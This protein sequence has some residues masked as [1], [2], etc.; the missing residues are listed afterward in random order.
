MKIFVLLTAVLLG[1]CSSADIHIA[2]CQ[3]RDGLQPVCGIQTPEDIAALDDGRHLLLAH[4]GGMIGGLGSLSLFDTQTESVTPLFPS[5]FAVVDVASATW[6]DTDC[7]APNPEKFNPHGTHLHRLADGALRY[8]V[9]NHGER[10]TV[11]M[12]EVLGNGSATGLQWRGCLEPAADTFM[13]D[14]VGLSNGDVIYT[15]MFHNAGTAEMLLSLIG[16]NTGDLWR[17]SKQAGPQLLPGTT[18][19]QPNGLEISPDE[20]HVFANMY[21]TQELWKVDVDTGEIVDVAAVA[22]ADNSAWGSDGR[23]WVTTHTAP[24]SDMIACAGSQELACG[25]GFAVIAVDADTMETETVFAHAGPP[26]GAATVAVPQAGR[27]YMGSFV[28]DR[29]M[30]SADFLPPGP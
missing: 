24:L 22:N 2:D 10:E 18:A 17:W 1:A 20:R 11:E 7:A 9:V 25:A 4:F 27:V 23:L 19:N 28:G 29:L 15:R 21:V 16:F 12:F 8:L 30:S 26:M 5:A 13:N 6:G 3:P 14:V